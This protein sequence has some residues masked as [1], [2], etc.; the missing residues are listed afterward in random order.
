VWSSDSPSLWLWLLVL[1]MVGVGYRFDLACGYRF[2]LAFA[3]AWPGRGGA[4][5]DCGVGGWA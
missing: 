1:L 2:D 4:L 3:S 5:S